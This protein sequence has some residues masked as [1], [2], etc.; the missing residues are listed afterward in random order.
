MRTH[1]LNVQR[2]WKNWGRME[3]KRT[4]WQSHK[5]KSIARELPGKG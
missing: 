4:E 3:E 5:T 1:V 2:E